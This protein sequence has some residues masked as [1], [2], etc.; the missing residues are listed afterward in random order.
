MM[1]LNPD[2][3]GNAEF[4]TI[5]DIVAKSPRGTAL[6]PLN[7]CLEYIRTLKTPRRQERPERRKRKCAT[8]IENLTRKDNSAKL[9]CK[10]MDWK[11]SKEE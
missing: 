5:P 9:L 11:F 10:S 1:S 4:G 6:N 7:A 2:G 8:L 3:R